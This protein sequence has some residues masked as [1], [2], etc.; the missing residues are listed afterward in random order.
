LEGIKEIFVKIL[1]VCLGNICRSPL[2]DGILRR[3]LAERNIDAFVDSAGTIANHVG[4]KPD[5]RMIS[6][7]KNRGTDISFLRARKFIKSDF[8]N[9]DY[10]FVMDKSNFDN[11]NLLADSIEE[12]NKVKMI[13]NEVQANENLEV[14]DP[15]YGGQA[16]FEHVYDLLDEATDKIIEKYLMNKN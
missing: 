10:I 11:V 14:P 7:A 5:S 2:A 16:G 4:E 1:F 6:T 9:F 3:K 13:L 12:K 15:Y 8:K